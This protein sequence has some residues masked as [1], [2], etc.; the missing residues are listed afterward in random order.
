[1]Q[2]HRENFPPTSSK[3]LLFLQASIWSFWELQSV[4]IAWI[5]AVFLL[6]ENLKMWYL[7]LLFYKQIIYVQK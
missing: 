5:H 3:R 1:M 7:N 6:S 4:A 2:A